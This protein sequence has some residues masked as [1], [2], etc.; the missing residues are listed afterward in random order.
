MF[1][2][3]TSFNA[4]ISAWDTSSVTDMQCFMM[5]AFNDS[6]FRWDVSSVTNMD[7]MFAWGDIVQRTS[8][9]GFCELRDGHDWHVL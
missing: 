2:G 5:R 8:Q 9:D 1:A 6:S 7:G 3:A 4:D